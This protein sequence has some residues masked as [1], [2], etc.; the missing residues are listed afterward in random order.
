MFRSRTPARKPAARLCPPSYRRGLRLEWLEDRTTPA[1]LFV[2]DS[3]VAGTALGSLPASIQVTAD[4]DGSG[5]LTTGDRVTIAAGETGT[6]ANLTFNAAANTG[7][8]DVGSVYSTITAAVAAAAAGDTI[9]IAKGT[10]A[11]SVTIASS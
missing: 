4:R 2:D 10:Y 5:T 8:G 7:A 3:L 6:T 9:A 11:E 1:T